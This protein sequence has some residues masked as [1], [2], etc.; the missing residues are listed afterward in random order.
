H[1]LSLYCKCH[2][3]TGGEMIYC[4]TCLNWFH[5][6]CMK[7]NLTASDIA[8]LALKESYKCPYCCKKTEIKNNLLGSRTIT[9]YTK[10]SPRMKNNYLHVGSRTITLASKQ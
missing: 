10:Q 7:Q 6:S 9:Y 2:K 8:R 1:K 4:D 3:H 5:F